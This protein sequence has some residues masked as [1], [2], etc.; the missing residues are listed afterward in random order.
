MAGTQQSCSVFVLGASG[1]LGRMVRAAWTPDSFHLVPVVRS[2]PVP[3]GGVRWDPGH[4]APNSG[5][6]TAVVALWGVTPGPGRDLS[7]NT[8][9]A[10]AAMDVG[11]AVGAKAVLHCSSAA[12]YRPGG[13][14][15]TEDMAGDPPSDY[16]R[17]KLQMEQAI[18]ARGRPEGPRQIVMRIGNVAGADSL[19]ANL[20]PSARLTLDRF[21]DGAG[22]TRS[23]ITAG[24]LGHVIAAFIRTETAQGIYNV[25]APVPT[26]MADLVR[27]GGG[28]LT[29]RDAPEGAA[30]QVWMDTGKLRSVID[31][32]KDA[33]GAEHLVQGARAGGVWP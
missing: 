8:R 13:D 7:D 1:K 6:V 32:S 26:P 15:L 21:P 25:S 23:Y 22:P 20:R 4:T 31:L 9:L 10:L 30:R 28:E 16:G 5:K 18:A 17:A 19:F 33:A 2:G 3:D 24:D 14:P 29:W 12:V 11:E 27:S